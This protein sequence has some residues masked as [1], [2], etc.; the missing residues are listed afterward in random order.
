M[1]ENFEYDLPADFWVLV[2]LLS[3]FGTE[4]F[5]IVVQKYLEKYRRD[6]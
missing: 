4:E 6:K 1:E 5:E 2:L 3:V